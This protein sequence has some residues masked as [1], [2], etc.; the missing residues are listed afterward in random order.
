MGP[1]SWGEEDRVNLDPVKIELIDNSRDMISSRKTVNHLETS[2]NPVRSAN[3]QCIKYNNSQHWQLLYSNQ[4]TGIN[5]NQPP[6]LDLKT[7][8]I[9]AEIQNCLMKTFTY[10][11]W[12]LNIIF[13]TFTYNWLIF[14]QKYWNLEVKLSVD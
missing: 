10:N 13:T 11:I 5:S 2:D 1:S 7:S 3:D 6:L 8:K 4:H 12:Y 9:A 14:V